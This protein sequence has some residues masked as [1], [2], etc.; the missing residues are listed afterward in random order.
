MCITLKCASQNYPGEPAKQ[1]LF[2]LQYFETFIDM[3]EKSFFLNTGMMIYC[4]LLCKGEI[5]ATL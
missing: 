3:P 5:H 4:N 2:I 1:E